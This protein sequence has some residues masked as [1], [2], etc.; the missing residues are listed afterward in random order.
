MVP[1][2]TRGVPGRVKDR[3]PLDPR[4]LTLYPLQEEIN[5]AA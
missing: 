2:R 3:V 1:S 5:H 4:P